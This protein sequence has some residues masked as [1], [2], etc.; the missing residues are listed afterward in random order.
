MNK[1]NMIDRS[2]TTESRILI[3]YVGMCAF[4]VVSSSSLFVGPFLE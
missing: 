4:S 1:Y 3:R 2:T